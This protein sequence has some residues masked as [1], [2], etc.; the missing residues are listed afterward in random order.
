MPGTPRSRGCD[1]CRRQKKK[2]DQEKPK[3]SRCMR[4]GIECTGAGQQRWKFQEQTI[5]GQSLT[6][7]SQALHNG[8]PSQSPNANL[9]NSS[10]MTSGGLVALLQITDLRYD[11]SVYGTYWDRIPRRMGTCEALDTAV[12]AFLQGHRNTL[13][14]NI[15]IES[16]AAFGKALRSTQAALSDPKQAYTGN[17]LCAVSILA[18]TQTM[19]V[20][21]PDPYVNH[22]AVLAHILPGI[23]EQG[24][25]SRFD[26]EVL[27]TASVSLI[28]ICIFRH[29]IPLHE[30]LTPLLRQYTGPRPWKSNHGNPF[31]SIEIHKLLNLPYYLREPEKYGPDIREAYAILREDIPEARNRL[32]RLAERNS[33]EIELASAMKSTIEKQHARF[34]IVY[35]ILLGLALFMNGLLDALSDAQDL[36]WP[37]VDECV[38]LREEALKLGHDMLGL[39][40]LYGAGVLNPMI[41]AWTLESEQA[42]REELE[43]VLAEYNEFPA[44]A[45]NWYSGAIWLRAYLKRLKARV[46]ME[47]ARLE[48]ISLPEKERLTLIDNEPLPEIAAGSCVIL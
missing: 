32:A 20:K 11:I 3:C 47:K 35:G 12:A 29:D 14:R 2:C 26:H 40:P 48:L 36:E 37:L 25:T 15:S 21:P 43:N 8:Q 31:R 16:L 41:M 5:H 13:S 44:P 28:Y 42:K 33:V 38:S 46:A 18:I 17:V 6:A 9:S 23:I 4:L 7:Q 39:R 30:S 24:W 19:V 34:Q 10:T 22:T 27:I 45:Q 1:N